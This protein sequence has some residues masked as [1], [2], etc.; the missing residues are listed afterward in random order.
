MQI[1]TYNTTRFRLK[2]KI[3][4]T[5]VREIFVGVEDERQRTKAES[6]QTFERGEEVQL[7]FSFLFYFTYYTLKR[8]RLEEKSKY[9]V[10]LNKGIFV[11]SPQIYPKSNFFLPLILKLIFYRIFSLFF[12]NFPNPSPPFTLSLFHPSNFSQN[13]LSPDFHRHRK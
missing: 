5:T 4:Q 12:G 13:P 11:I 8:E 7:S 3:K 1:Y 6:W 10:K 9:E 2:N